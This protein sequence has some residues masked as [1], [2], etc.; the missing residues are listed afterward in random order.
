MT[1]LF[2]TFQEE[3]KGRIYFDLIDYA[4]VKAKCKYVSLI[5][6]PTEPLSAS[7]VKAL[8]LLNPF[9]LESKEVTEWPGTKLLNR[10]AQLYKYDF[11]VALAHELKLLTSRLYQW[12]YPALPED[13][14]LMIS[15]KLPWLF[16]IAHEKDA[17]LCLN[18]DEL[19]DIQKQSDLSSLL[20]QDKD[21]RE[22]AE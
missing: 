21:Y 18:T 10:S 11:V 7:G 13:L 20:I 17:V 15:D 1:R 8:E 16:T 4:L 3:P 14:C 2:F 12:R 22:V 5:V 19:E 6:Y 9:L